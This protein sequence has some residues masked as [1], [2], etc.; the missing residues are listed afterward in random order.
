MF[1]LSSSKHDGLAGSRFGWA[2]VRDAD[3]ASSMWGV[4]YS[5]TIGVSVDIEMRVLTSME[6]ILS[7]ICIILSPQGLIKIV[8]RPL[9]PLLILPHAS[10]KSTYL[11]IQM[12][13]CR[14]RMEQCCPS[15]SLDGTKCTRDSPGC[16]QHWIPAPL[17]CSSRTLPP[18]L[19]PMPGY[20]ALGTSSVQ[21]SLLRSM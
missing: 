4:V 6:A 13:Q 5:M 16:T 8:V 3:L 17:S 18:P 7:K 2:L 21:I 11:L 15:I 12:I 14:A 1:L 20:T 9:Q 19:G 10:H